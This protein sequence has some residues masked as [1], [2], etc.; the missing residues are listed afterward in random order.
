MVA[1]TQRPV[2]NGL[3]SDVDEAVK[4]LA[5]PPVIGFRMTFQRENGRFNLRY[6]SSRLAWF[7]FRLGQTSVLR[8]FPMQVYPAAPLQIGTFPNQ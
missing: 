7:G 8:A 2:I 3:P 1:N 6:F 5:I 4:M